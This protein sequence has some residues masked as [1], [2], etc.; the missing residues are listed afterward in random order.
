MMAWAVLQFAS[1]NVTEA[2][3]T[4]AVV[5]SPLAMLIVTD[6]VGS[7]SSLMVYLP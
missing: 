2:G 3:L 5:V 4:V 1:V 6:P 7:E